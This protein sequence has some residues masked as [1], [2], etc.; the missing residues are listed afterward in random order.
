MKNL[1]ENHILLEVKMF[2][3]IDEDPYQFVLLDLTCHDLELGYEKNHQ[4]ES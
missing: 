4:T 2:V 3:L 1:L